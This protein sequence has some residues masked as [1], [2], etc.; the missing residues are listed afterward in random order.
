MNIQMGE[1][2][3]NEINSAFI[4]YENHNNDNGFMDCDINNFERG[5][6]ER[7]YEPIGICKQVPFE[8]PYAKHSVAF[9]YK[10]EEELYWCH[11]TEIIWYSLLSDVYGRKEA[12]NIISNIMGYKE[13]KK[14]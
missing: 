6:I 1:I 7:N 11:L 14:I 10:Y 4:S 9:C 3:Q 12:D 2:L 8:A 13:E 5:L